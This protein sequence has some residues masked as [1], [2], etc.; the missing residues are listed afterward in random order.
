VID[1]SGVS[2]EEVLVQRGCRVKGGGGQKQD[3]R[4]GQMGEGGRAM[5]GVVAARQR[6]HV[7]TDRI[8]KVCNDCTGD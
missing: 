4:V 5:K 1:V 7:A 8:D 3:R 6:E 2:T